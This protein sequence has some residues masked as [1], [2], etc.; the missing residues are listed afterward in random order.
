MTINVFLYY[1]YLK[2]VIDLFQ[3]NFHFRLQVYDCKIIL[4]LNEFIE[5]DNYFRNI[6]ACQ[7]HAI[8]YQ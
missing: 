6:A 4:N 1:Q 3:S 5:C 8:N 7:F 2:A